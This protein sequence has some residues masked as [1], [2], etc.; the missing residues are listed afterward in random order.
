MINVLPTYRALINDE[1][2]GIFVI[3]LVD[4]PATEINWVTFGK[5]QQQ[6]F[7]VVDESKHILAGV[8]MVAD[9]PIYRIAP[10]GQEYYIVF[11]KDVIAHMAEKMLKDNTFNNIDI[12]HNGELLSEGMIQLTEL[13]IKDSS[14]GISPN[15]V[16]VPD[17]SLMANYKI[18]DDKLWNEVTNG[19]LHGFSLEGVFS[20][21]RVVEPAF[22]TK[23]NYNYKMNHIKDTLRKLLISLGEVTT[24][25]GVL[26]Y[27]DEL[28]TG[29]AVYINDEPAADGEY[30][31][32]DIIV[33]VRDGKVEELKEVEHPTDEQ[34][35]SDVEDEVETV[36]DD[37]TAARL[38]EFD[39]KLVELADRITELENMLNELNKSTVVESIEESTFEKSIKTNS[40]KAIDMARYLKN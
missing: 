21:I 25:K 1:Q 8:V 15:Y 33:V 31:A 27:E 2:E 6:K 11:T 29:I 5:Q 16:D 9:T 40:N 30:I 39:N 12:Q 38:D 28:T 34:L 19:D 32:E 4:M 13:F 20:S 18:Y 26:T 36:E 10:D 23:Y 14:L 7:S 3:S 24:D 37:D 17:G 22:E 35:E